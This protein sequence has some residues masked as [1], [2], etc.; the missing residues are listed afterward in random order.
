MLKGRLGLETARVPHKD[1]HGLIW[2]RRGLVS[3]RDGTLVF[4]SGP[5]GS[6]A[7][8][9]YDIPFQMLSALMLETGTSITHD[10]LRLC[11]RHG[12]GVLAV[13][14]DGVRLYSAMPFGPDDSKIA[15]SQVYQWSHQELRRHVARRLYAF[16]LGEIMPD[17]P[18]EVLRGIEGARAKESYKLFAQR[19]QIPWEGRRY[20]RSNPGADDPINSAINHA[21]VATL[22]AAQVAVAAVGAIPQLGFIHEDSGMALCLDLADSFRDEVTLTGAFSGLQRAQR[23]RIDI[24]TAVRRTTGR[25]LREQQ[26]IPTMIDRLKTLFSS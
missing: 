5:E 4:S 12:V 18:I 7:D 16:K 25:I 26:I 2:L 1:R 21:S 9:A 11:A 14:E 6:P 23:E 24:E 17:A 22:A 3:V 10:A 19:Y 13:G 20:D 15:R 8:G